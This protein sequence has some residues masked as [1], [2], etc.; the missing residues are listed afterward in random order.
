MGTFYK[1]LYDDTCEVLGIETLFAYMKENTKGADVKIHYKGFTSNLFKV[2]V[3]HL[4]Q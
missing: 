2:L 4:R 3:S 1:G